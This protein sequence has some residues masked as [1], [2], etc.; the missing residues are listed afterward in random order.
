MTTDEISANIA[1]AATLGA[2]ATITLK[3]STVAQNAAAVR[4][5]YKDMT[6]LQAVFTGEF[7]STLTD[8][9]LQNAFGLTAGQVTALRTNTLTPAANLAASIRLTTGA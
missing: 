2:D 1:A 4:A 8:N 6:Q 5:V 3:E 7:L 9:Q